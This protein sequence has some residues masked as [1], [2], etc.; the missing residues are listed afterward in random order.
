MS[1]TSE[2]ASKRASLTLYIRLRIYGA[3]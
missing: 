2:E 1:D 3:V